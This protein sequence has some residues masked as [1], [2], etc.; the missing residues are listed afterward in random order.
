MDTAIL[1]PSGI[2][3]AADRLAAANFRANLTALVQRQ[4]ELADRIGSVPPIVRWIFARD[5]YLTART[6]TGWWSGCSVPLATGRELLKQLVLLGH[7]GCFLNPTH[8]AQIRSCFEKLQA[9]QAV[10]AVIPDIDS[11]RIMLRCDDFTAEIA[12]ARLFFV[13]GADWADQLD[14]FFARH[15]GLPLPQQFLRTALLDDADMA[16]FTTEAQAIISRETSR[17]SERLPA[18]LASAAGRP[19]SGRTVVLAGSR[20]NLADLSN[21]GL[22]CA[23]LDK[24]DGLDFVP[25]DPDYPL[26]ASPLALAE[27]AAQADA[28]IT[29]DLFRSD[30]AGIVSPQTAWITWL[31][32]GRVVAP[33]L[34][35]PADAL[36][37]ADPE[38]LQPA[39]DAGWP[40]ERV[41]TAAW[42][43]I[44]APPNTPHSSSV[45]GLLAD[46]CVL[47]IPK[48]VEAFS[49]QRLLWE[50]IEEEISDRPWALGDNP[51]KYL[52][53]RMTRVNIAEEGFDRGLFIEKLIVPA[54]Q[55]GLSRFLLRS[56][57]GLALYGRGWTEMPE[58]Q[59]HARGP[60][61]SLDGLSRAVSECDA[62]L[63]PFPGRHASMNAM[64]LPIIQPAGLPPDRILAQIRKTL[65]SKRPASHPNP[66]AL[67]RNAILSL[68]RR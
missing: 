35:A 39:L 12:N 5:G 10:I 18:I 37:L 23:L 55:S 38:W 2:A 52:Q 41:H 29:A 63:H 54:Y 3:T 19:R 15:Q 68:N 60:I 50:M 62:L 17:R 64:P 32:T 42:P 13:S 44:I 9:N 4:P 61:T 25:L 6:E 57:I 45:V 48:S 67:S 31:T 34:H 51:E 40:A 49:S 24:D 47:E 30:L 20:F 53:S 36:L 8:A 66:L 22:R 28:L 11:L 46:T 58:F 65:C 16:P 7:V 56:G 43:R 59:P 33:D 21:L 1:S 14:T 26:T 27:A